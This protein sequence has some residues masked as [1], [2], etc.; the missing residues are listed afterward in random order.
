MTFNP[1]KPSLK[2]RIC[3]K[4]RYI[5]SARKHPNVDFFCCC[6]IS[7]SEVIAAARFASSGAACLIH[8]KVRMGGGLDLT[9]RTADP[10]F[11]SALSSFLAQVLQ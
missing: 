7:A 9:V 8:C 6:S 3:S 10:A 1:S 5:Y 11:S 2:V 4:R